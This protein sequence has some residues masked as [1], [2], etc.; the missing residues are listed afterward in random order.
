M[1]MLAKVVCS[2]GGA[3]EWEG[4]SRAGMWNHL[5][6]GWVNLWPEAQG[7]SREQ[8]P[9]QRRCLEPR[10]RPHLLLLFRPV[11]NSPPVRTAP[12][13]AMPAGKMRTV[14]RLPTPAT[15]TMELCAASAVYWT[16]T[17]PQSQNPAQ[18]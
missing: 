1:H 14:F 9:C 4:S 18:Q 15:A 13:A 5:P 11:P 10:H 17:V 3:G 16:G 8:L 2:V 6:E 7:L 12:A